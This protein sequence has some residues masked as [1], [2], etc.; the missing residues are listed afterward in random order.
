MCDK[1][2]TTEELNYFRVCYINTS[3]IRDGLETVFKQ[4]WDRVYGASL[5]TWR[6]TAKNGQ[7]F[8]N[9]ESP[10]S[11][12]RNIELLKTIQNGNTNEWDPT[13][14]FFA[15]L[16][17]DSLGPFVN[18]KIALNVDAL[19]SFRNRV[20]AHPFQPSILETD[21]QANMTLVTNAFTVLH[22]DTTHLQ[23]II[24]QGSFPTEELRQLQEQ[25]DVLEEELQ[26]KPKSFICLPPKP[27]HEVI[28]RK[29]EAGEIMDLFRD[30]QE[31]NDD[32]S[33]VRVY[34]DGNPGCGKSQVVRDVG[35]KM[36]DEAL[37]N[38]DQESCTFVMTFNA[39]STK[40]LL[41]SYYKFARELGVT[42]YSLTSMTGADGERI[43][44]LKTLVC[45]KVQQYSSW[46]LIFDNAN[47][48]KK[49]VKKSYWPDEEWGAC[50]KVLVTTQDSLHKPFADTSC[51]SI[52]LSRGMQ[53][54]DALSLLRL[55]SQLSCDDQELEHSVVKA[56]DFQPL[57]IACAAI[58]ARYLHSSVNLS[59]TVPGSSIWKN[60]LQKLTIGKRRLTEQVYERTSDSYR[61]SMT[62]AVTMAVEKIIQNEVFRHVVHFLG[63][64]A[65]EPIDLNIIVSFVTNQDP[66]LDEDIAAADIVKCSLLIPLT[67]DDGPGTRIH[68]HKVV[69]DVFKRQLDKC[70]LEEFVALSQTYIKTLSVFADHNP[71][72]F[73]LKFHVSSKM[74]APHLKSLSGHLGPSHN[75]GDNWILPDVSDVSSDEWYDLQH[76]FLNFGDICS[77]HDYCSAART[78]FELALDMATNE[79]DANDEKG[80]KF[81]AAVLNKLGVLDRKS[82]HFSKAKDLHQRAL[83][84]LENVH[85]GD[86]TSEIADCLEKLGNVFYCLGNFEE[87]KTCHCRSLA[88]RERVFDG[89]HATVADSLNNLGCV[90]SALGDPQ[91]AENYYQRSLA[92]VENLYGKLHP[93]VADCLSNLGIVYSELGATEKAIEYHNRALEMRKELYFPDHFLIS[94]SYNNLG[95]MYK[96]LGQLE[97]A[98]ACLESALRIREKVLDKYHPLM[99][100]LLDN[101]GQMHIKRGEFQKCKECYYQALDIRLKKFGRHCKTAASLLNLGLVHE[102]CLEFHDA[103]SFFKDALEMY[104]KRYQQTHHLWQITAES[105]QRVSQM[106]HSEEAQEPESP[107]RKRTKN[108]LTYSGVKWWGAK[109]RGAAPPQRKTRRKENNCDCCIFMLIILALFLMQLC[110]L[111]FFFFVY[112]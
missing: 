99:G 80:V 92:I 46:L 27:S 83:T 5:G 35:K 111:V 52:S 41:D 57:A 8:F 60:Y 24:K 59:R 47:D 64:C 97:K 45:A 62:S 2:Y 112:N 53:M 105:L 22:L 63:L 51:G 9:M 12:R 18:P 38:G 91:T 72:Q 87:A 17:S 75:Q 58:Y 104:P 77:E 26:A 10:R 73:D 88:M 84:L 95:L 34:V 21:F 69:H 79:V 23:K 39:E 31:K 65:P 4:E 107:D 37:T 89:K 110:F 32:G 50:G 15:I 55:V 76:A 103:A 81:K 40:S 3:I 54:D 20:F 70:N 86:Q 71:V 68:V 90:Y 11:Q 36:Y 13:C 44:Q 1:E 78:F 82:G 108:T 93:H 56:L 102:R 100:E 42:E 74:M 28:E 49:S 33:I 106:K 101:L 66:D 6:D 14:F 19:R 43:S 25:V 67:P 48:L 98:M 61:C 96:D 85:S 29:A 109:L 16:Y 94:E 30:L 7:D